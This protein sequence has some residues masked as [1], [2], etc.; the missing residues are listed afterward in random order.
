MAA[1]TGTGT[2]A[3]RGKA[4]KDRACLTLGGFAPSGMPDVPNPDYSGAVVARLYGS[5]GARAQPDRLERQRAA[6]IARW[7]PESQI[8]ETAPFDAALVNFRL[9]PYERLGSL[10][11]GLDEGIDVLLKLFD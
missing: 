10:V 9:G 8:A 2:P 11:I 7:Y 4:G 5:R 6:S 3:R 1:V